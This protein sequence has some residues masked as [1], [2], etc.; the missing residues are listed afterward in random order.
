MASKRRAVFAINWMEV[1]ALVNARHDNPHH[2][3]GIHECLDDVYV[4]AFIPGAKV[5]TVI[6]K[7]DKKRYSLISERYEGFFSI[8]IKDKKSF[9]YELDIKYEDGTEQKTVDPYVFEP[10]IDPIDISRFNEGIHYEIYEKLGSHPM[11]VDGVKGTLFAVWAPNAER[12]SVV[13]NF[14][15]WDGRRH[16]MRKLDYSGIFELFIPGN[17]TDEIYKYEIRSK[18][19]DVFMKSD[20]YAFTSEIRP[21][22]ASK[23]T[24]L[25]YIWHDKKWIDAR[26]SSNEGAKDDKVPLE[27][28]LNIYEVHLGS[29]KRPDD[30]REFYSYREIAIRLADYMKEMGYNYV[31]LMPIM[32]HPYDPS[33]GYQITGYYAPTSRYGSPEEFMGFVDYM[34]TKGIGVIIDWVP[35]H[36]PRDEHGL[37]R[38]DGTPLYENQDPLRGEHPH[39]GTY[40]FDYGRNEVKNF[41]VANALYWADKYHIDGIRVDAVAS[42]LYLDYGRNGGEWRPNIYGGNENLEAIAFIKEVNQKMKENYPGVIMIAEEST[43]WPMM[44]HNVEDGGM[45]FDYKWNMGWMN[46]FLSYMKLDPLYR[47]YHHNELTFSMMYAFSEKFI[48]VL[49]HDEVVHEKGSMI[50]KMPGGYEDKF[51]NLRTAY[52]FMMTHPGKKLIFMG[53]EFA[54]FAE[55]NESSELD[56]SLFEFDAH[57]CIQDYVKELN[58]LYN[59]EPALYEYDSSPEGFN[60]ISVNDANRSIVSYERNAKNE[61]DTLVVVCNF[62]PVEQKNYKLGVPSEGKWQEIFSSD[63]AKFGGEGK[64]NKTVRQTKVGS[65]DERNQYIQITVPALSVSVFKKKSGSKSPAKKTAK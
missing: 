21:A 34:H 49:S 52:G 65:V 53:Q 10:V 16:Q 43:A 22:N 45:G 42:M 5:V 23:V 14:N 59:S 36:F 17:L 33:W 40:I 60:W 61:K 7:K 20:P 29:W 8:C 24:T 57:R 39:W 2:I 25:D 37:G 9:D 41:L 3:L 35:A 18:K 55:F 63:N 54:Q 46:D 51:S 1:E 31:E 30:G 4:N 28:P 38:F 11:V 27:K 13:G 15:N 12:V 32:E 64:N 6:D 44:T 58:K 19:G 47:K 50:Q 26:S 56:W 62:T 48:L